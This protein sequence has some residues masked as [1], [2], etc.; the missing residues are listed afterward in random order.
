MCPGL[1]PLGTE[2][3][4]GHPRVERH[5]GH[6]LHR[7]RRHEALPPRAARNRDRR[8]PTG[9]RSGSR[10][11]TA[12]RR[13]P[14]REEIKRA[15][16]ADPKKHPLR[17]LIAT[18][19]AREGLNLQTHCW[20]LF[21][22]DV[23]WNPSR[24]EQRNGRI[25]RKLQPQPEVRCHYF[26][27]RQRPED[28]MLKVLV[29]KTETIKRELGSLAQVVEGRL[30]ETLEHGIRH[31][32]VADASSGGSTP[33]DLEAENKQTV[34]EELEAA[35]ERQEEL[36]GQIDQLRNRLED[37]EEVDRARARTHFRAA[38][39]CA[40][41][42][43][44]AEPLTPVPN[45]GDWAK[46]LQRYASPPSTSRPAPTRPGPTPWTPCAPRGAATRS[47]GS[48][49]A[50][51]R[52][53]PVVFEDPGTMDDDVVHL[54]LE[55]RVVQRLL[56]RFTAQGFVH[57]DLSRACLAQ[58]PTPSRASSSSAGSASTAA[59]RPAPRGDRPGHGALGRALATEAAAHALRREAETKT[60][61]LLEERCCRQARPTGQRRDAGAAPG[62]RGA[63]RAT[64]CSRTCETRGRELAERCREAAGRAGRARGAGH[65]RDPR[66]AEE[67]GRR[68]GREVPTTRSCDARTS[69]A[70]SSAQLEANKRHW[71]KRLAAID[72]ELATEPERIRAVYD[73]KAQR[74]EPVGLVYLWPVTG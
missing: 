13:R 22:F 14:K 42:L 48:G 39:S 33:T 52:S 57:H 2:E 23:P 58:T 5:A 34:E 26:V 35:R 30:A 68:D 67:A 32:D 15:F 11:I 69:T 63:R 59:G 41:E 4:H 72:R 3:P 53:A 12:R 74:I 55:H 61:E 65:A 37:L 66:D 17:I 56:G 19:A 25:D 44:G 29:R 43:V 36:Q 1:P 50:S 62:G 47:P 46:P 10:S 21:H 51:R 8:A 20:N 60:L 73:V 9:P 16:N 49:G 71:E 24:M 18:D 31:R 27:Y 6:H 64:S 40:L 28:R 45:G 38:L 54:H 7:V 70:T